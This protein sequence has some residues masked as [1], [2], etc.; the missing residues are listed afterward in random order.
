MWS[1]YS[2]NGPLV[3]RAASYYTVIQCRL[4]RLLVLFSH[5]IFL[6]GGNQLVVLLIRSKYWISKIKNLVKAVRNSCKLCTIYK[7]RLQTQLMAIFLPFE[8]PFPG[9]LHN[10]HWLCRPVWDKKLYRQSKPYYQGICLRVCVFLH[11]GYPFRAN[12]RPDNR[13][14]PRGICPIRS[15]KRLSPAGPFGY[16]KTFVRAATLLS[17][18][19]MQT[20]KESVTDTY[21]HQ[22][23]LWRILQELDNSYYYIFLDYYSPFSYTSLHPKCPKKDD[24]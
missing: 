24:C 1:H 16:G 6:H 20:I 7:K 13:E 8:F 10:W 9:H 17:R 18:D 14:V 5:Q 11:K 23:I 12:V 15:E 22:G 3:W 19:F 21:S 2:L 4:D